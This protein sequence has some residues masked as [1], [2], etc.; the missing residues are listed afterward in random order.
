MLIEDWS[1][2]WKRAN[3]PKQGSQVLIAQSPG[4]CKQRLVREGGLQRLSFLD[5][6]DQIK[7][8]FLPRNSSCGM[9]RRGACFPIFRA[10]TCL[11]G[12]LSFRL[13]CQKAGNETLYFLHPHAPPAGS[14]PR[15]LMGAGGASGA[16]HP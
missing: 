14:V 12:G 8:L 9:G 13:P 15:L 16:Q 1:W 6:G 3:F 7:S 5:G 2:F 10:L 11:N 4:Q